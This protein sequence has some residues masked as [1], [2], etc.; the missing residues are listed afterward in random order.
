MSLNGYID[1]DDAQRVIEYLNLNPP[2]PSGPRGFA[3]PVYDVN[4]DGYIS[5]IDVLLIINFLNFNSD[6]GSL[7]VPRNALGAQASYL[8]SSAQAGAPLTGLVTQLSVTTGRATGNQ[9]TQYQYYATPG[10]VSTHGQLHYVIES[11]G[12]GQAT[13]ELNYDSRGNVSRVVDPAGRITQFYYDTRD[14]LTAVPYP[15]PDGS[16]PLL[17]PVERY[18]YDVFGHVIATELVNSYLENSQLL[19]TSLIDGST[20]DAA[21]RLTGQYAQDPDLT[22]YL[23]RDA[24]GNITR[25][26]DKATALASLTVTTMALTA[27]AAGNSRITSSNT[28]G[29]VLTP[30]NDPTTWGLV[31]TYT[32]D[33]NGNVIEATEF[34]GGLAN[35][36]LPPQ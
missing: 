25:T 3:E 30:V 6:P 2:Q 27:W 36:E 22:W 18:D 16:G 17:S 11:P 35:P 14:R 31:Y 34:D 8:Y 1:L 13:T 23:K 32:Y 28:V 19:V 15:D 12:A 10:T 5:S 29:T 26:S 20:Y 7:Y 9:V 4:N 33:L 24:A 21:H